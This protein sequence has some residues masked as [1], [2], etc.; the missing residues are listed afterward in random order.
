MTFGLRNALLS[1]R[2][3]YLACLAVLL[4]LLHL[5]TSSRFDHND[6]MYAIAPLRSGVL[7]T[8]V[9]YVQAPLGYYWPKLINQAVP[10]HDWYFALR[11]LSVL[12]SAGA[13]LLLANVYLQ[14]RANKLLFLAL[15]CTDA[16]LI[17]CALEVG[18]YS[19]PLFLLAAGIYLLKSVGNSKISMLVAGLSL[20]LAASYKINYIL[21]AP[22]LA[23][24]ALGKVE[25]GDIARPLLRLFAGFLTGFMPTLYFL[26]TQPDAFI[27]HNVSF[28]AELTKAY[29]V[30]TGD[31]ASNGLVTGFAEF[32][33]LRNLSLFAALTFGVMSV[34]R[35]WRRQDTELLCLMS[36]AALSILG[37]G[38]G[39]KQYFAPLAVLLCLWVAAQAPIGTDVIRRPLRALA[40]PLLLACL[41]ATLMNLRQALPDMRATVRRGPVSQ[42][43]SRINALVT[44][45]LS[46]RHLANIDIFTFSGLFVHEAP[47]AKL[48]CADAGIFW[49]RLNRLPAKKLPLGKVTSTARSTQKQD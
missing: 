12:F 28:H 32:W 1:I 17:A 47:F 3:G 43:I 48:A 5:S 29:R 22:A 8:E 30:M 2:F 27:L 46:A 49:A 18:S 44:Q 38:Y 21:F 26:L 10:A 11:E 24:I 45:A 14:S 19:Q 35:S 31:A 39:F 6:F 13:L 23:F 40:S 25:R 41:F 7:Y 42:E 34:R 4:T 15:S 37:T 33:G 20:G 16:Y 9:H 36:C